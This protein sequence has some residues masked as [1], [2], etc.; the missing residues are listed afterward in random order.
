VLIGGD[1]TSIDGTP[2]NRIARLNADGSLDTGFDPGI[3]ANGT[4][5][6][7]FQQV[8]GKVLI[9]G[10][11]TSIDGTTRR[12]IA[13][14]NADGSLDTGFDLGDDANTGVRAISQQADGT[15]L[16]SGVFTRIDGPAINFIVRLGT[17]EAALQAVSA[18]ANSR[19]IEWQRG[20]TSPTLN[21]V[22]FEY[23]ESLAGN[24]T[25]LGEGQRVTGGW[26]LTELSLP[27]E[28]IGYL[29]A[30]GFYRGGTFNGSESITESIHQFYLPQDLPQAEDD[31]FCLPIK[32][33]NG[34]LALICL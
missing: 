29:R 6:S 14:L 27:R 12:N 20:G 3:G 21:R 4:V 17:D 31:S 11:F 19:R 22:T 30:R 33:A 28:T 15:V 9:G 2:L 8:D 16:I 18:S 13:R 5:S 26:E 7:I 25:R 32:T 1:F 23:S 24:W 10:D 34:N